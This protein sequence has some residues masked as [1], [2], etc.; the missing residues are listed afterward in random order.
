M[1]SC[2]FFL[3][4]SFKIISG[5]EE[6]KSVRGEDLAD[7][8]TVFLTAI[9]SNLPKRVYL[10][11]DNYADYI[12]ALFNEAKVT[13]DLHLVPALMG[14]EKITLSGRQSVLCSQ[15]CTVFPFSDHN[16]NIDTV[17]Y[18]LSKLKS[19]SLVVAGQTVYNALGGLGQGENGVYA[20]IYSNNKYTM[21][22]Y[23]SPMCSQ[24]SL[25]TL[26]TPIN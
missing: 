25:K 16:D 2:L 13:C 5:K 19:Q 18:V 9:S 3:I 22:P 24:T 12:I 1:Q 11:S 26:Q 8:K 6:N 14:G 17:K 20:V 4:N 15:N 7:L 21:Y 23:T 10:G